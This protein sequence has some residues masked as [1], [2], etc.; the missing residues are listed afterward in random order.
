[1]VKKQKILLLVG[2]P[3]SGKSTWAHEFMQQGDNKEKWA[4]VN[5]DAIRMMIFANNYDSSTQENYVTIIED[6]AVTGALERGMSVIVDATNLNPKYKGRWYEMAE[7]YNADVEEKE[8]YIPFR[9]ALKRDK[10]RGEKG[11]ISV[12]KKVLRGFYQRYYRDRMNEDTYTDHRIITQPD[13]TLPNCVIV[14]LDG[15]YALH[16]A[17]DP[18]EWDA[19]PTDKEDPR[20]GLL[21]SQLGKMHT[22]IVFLTG[23]PDSAREMTSEWLLGT[24]GKRELDYELIM[25]DAKDFRSGEITK[26]ELYEKHVKGKYNVLA[27]FEDSNKCVKMWRE[28]GLLTCQVDEA[29]Y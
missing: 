17:R 15:T 18:F 27:V 10:E 12:G 3:A 26:Q 7:K 13:T 24:I 11:G 28:Q 6:T 25:R 20:L 16:V 22:H 1:M 8:F 4:V 23:R 5:R 19:I 2:P 9:E 29:D 21:L 14:D